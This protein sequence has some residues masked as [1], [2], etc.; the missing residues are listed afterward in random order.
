MGVHIDLG[1]LLPEIEIVAKRQNRLGDVDP[2]KIGNLAEEWA[3]FCKSPALLAETRSW[4]VRVLESRTRGTEVVVD[5]GFDLST[6]GVRTDIPLDA[7][8]FVTLGD[9]LECPTGDTEATYI[10]GSGLRARTFEDDFIEYLY[11]FQSRWLKGKSLN[12]AESY[13]T[14]EAIC[15]LNCDPSVVA[16]DPEIAGMELALI[17]GGP[18]RAS[19]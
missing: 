2:A 15:D 8:D 18:D 9:L 1:S 7:S 11:E 14:T 12:D 19:P 6:E 17:L 13:A 10:P 4:L 3:Q 16:C 5:T